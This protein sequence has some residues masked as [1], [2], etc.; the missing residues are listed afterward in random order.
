MSGVWSK[1]S[2]LFVFITFVVIYVTFVVRTAWVSDDAYITLR[3]VNNFINGYGLTWNITERVQAYTHPLWMLALSFVNF[4]T[5]EVFFTTIAVS[6]LF[7]LATIFWIAFKATRN[8]LVAASAVILL[9]GSKAYVDYSTSGLE[10]PM[11]HFLL[12]VFIYY[13]FLP[14]KNLRHLTFLAFIAALIML[15]RQDFA[16]IVIAPLVHTWHQIW[17]KSSVR[18]FAASFA[19]LIGFMPLILWL[20]FSLIYYG[21]PFPNTFYAKLYNN[22]PVQVY[23]QNGLAYVQDSFTRDPLTL[24]IVIIGTISAIIRPT[25]KRIIIVLGNL[26]YLAYVVYIGGD[27]MTGRFFTTPFLIAIY[28]LVDIAQNLPQTISWGILGIVLAGTTILSLSNWLSPLYADSFYGTRY[29]RGEAQIINGIADERGWYFQMNGMIR[30]SDGGR[31]MRNKPKLAGPI[32]SPPQ[33]V[34]IMGQVGTEAFKL[35]SDDYVIDYHALSDVFLARMPLSPVAGWRIGH[36]VRLVLPEYVESIKTGQNK[37]TDPIMADYYDT[38]K[39]IISDPIFS[40]TRWQKIYKMNFTSYP[41]TLFL[42]G[43]SVDLI[44]QS[45]EQKWTTL[46][47]KN[48]VAGEVRGPL[49]KADFHTE[50]YIQDY[51]NG[52]F[53]FSNAIG[54]RYLDSKIAQKWL[55]LGATRSAIGIPTTDV[56]AVVNNAYVVMFSSGA[57]YRSQS[58]VWAV[59]GQIY[60]KYVE[61]GEQTG[62]LGFPISD[63]T[64]LADGKTRISRFQNGAIFTSSDRGTWVEFG[65]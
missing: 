4:F 21:F 49:K 13:Y 18:L 23:I 45:I 57:I 48:G 27:F 10:N 34:I 64:P 11:S 8:F 47:G 54:A 31:P 42:R 2:T 62:Q 33:N 40:L 35:N 16:L 25:V 5:R 24:S 43:Q 6:I 58:G 61:L 36:M 52:V 53:I 28:L 59:Q 26:F 50:F 1:R 38:L 17:R 39:S 12:V 3:T 30:Q 44:Q 14:T 51:D 19:A 29:E 37:L 60:R 56:K 65:K 55:L 41:K 9:C 63:E 7:S 46:G 15:N 20:I 22:V 32:T